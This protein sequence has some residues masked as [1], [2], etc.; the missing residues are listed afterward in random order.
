MD[1]GRLAF[2]AFAAE[3]GRERRAQAEL[4]QHRALA[5]Q[6]DVV[7][8]HVT[9]GEAVFVAE[10][11]RVGHVVQDLRHF[12]RREAAVPVQ[13]EA[14]RLALRTGQHAPHQV[15]GGAGRQH[16]A[17]LRVAQPRRAFDRVEEPARVEAL[18]DVGRQHLHH[19]L[20]VRRV[21][22]E[23]QPAQAA[24]GEFP[25]HA[26]LPAQRLLQAR[27]EFGHGGT[28]VGARP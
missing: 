28:T 17:Q 7:G 24:E 10:G 26:V 18:R 16:R 14:Q 22:G 1:V 8:L 6:V 19:D 27:G 9:V 25:L 4:R 20:P 5:D 2:R 21:G 12:R 13:P 15:P 23:E 3:R 11:E